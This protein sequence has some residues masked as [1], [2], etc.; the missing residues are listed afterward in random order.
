MPTQLSQNEHA[1]EHTMSTYAV[2][3]SFMKKMKETFDLW[4]EDKSGYLDAKEFRGLCMNLYGE[5]VATPLKLNTW[6]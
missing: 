5:S 4:D 3:M 2:D 1:L 6:W